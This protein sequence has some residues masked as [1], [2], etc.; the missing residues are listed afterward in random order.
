[1]TILHSGSNNKY[2][3]NWEKAFAKGSPR[4]GSDKPESVRPKAKAKAKQ[5]TSPGGS[6]AAAPAKLT[7]KSAK[8][9]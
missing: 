2:S 3:S 9:K 8:K 7:K 4:K 1:M 6:P 5:Q